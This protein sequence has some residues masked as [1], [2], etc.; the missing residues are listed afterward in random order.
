MN[1]APY[2]D[3]TL[4]SATASLQDII[5]L[6]E[7]AMASK[8]AAV[9]VPPYYVLAAHEILI[10]TEVRTATVI[11]F[12]FGYSTT[13]SKLKEIEKALMDGADE[14]DIVQNLAALKSGDWQVLEQEITACTNLLHGTGKKLKVVIESGMLTNDEL[15]HCCT[16][17]NDY[18]VDFLKTSTGYA[19]VGATV[20][21][22]QYMRRHLIPTISIKASGGIKNFAFAQELILAGAD[23]LGCSASMKILEESK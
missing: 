5:K 8:F 16:L 19:A 17:Y 2:I 15:K 11:G 18:P 20:Q 22:V 10:A 7:E 13:E 21:A 3:H 1:I 14:L 12:P 4:L 6:C 23:R 9:C